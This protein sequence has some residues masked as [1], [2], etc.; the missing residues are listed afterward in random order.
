MMITRYSTYIIA[1]SMAGSK[2]VGSIDK[3]WPLEAK[4]KPKVKPVTESEKQNIIERFQKRI[5]KN[6]K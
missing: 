3:L 1:C 4:E 5:K 2:E 6:A